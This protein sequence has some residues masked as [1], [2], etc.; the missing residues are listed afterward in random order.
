MR[1]VYIIIGVY[2]ALCTISHKSK[3]R[4]IIA[5]QY[6]ECGNSR[7]HVT[8]TRSQHL[9]LHAIANHLLAQWRL[10]SELW[11]I[12]ES[13]VW[14]ICVINNDDLGIGLGTVSAQKYFLTKVRINFTMIRTHDHNI[15]YHLH[16]CPQRD[17]R[18]I[19]IG[20]DSFK[21][22]MCCVI[23][24]KLICGCLCCTS[25]RDMFTYGHNNTVMGNES[26]NPPCCESRPLLFYIIYTILPYI[27]KHMTV[28]YVLL[29]LSYT[30]VS[31][32]WTWL[33]SKSYNVL[34]SLNSL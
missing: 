17:C 4:E 34:L 19:G 26:F 7:R 3:F 5:R 22:F 8:K 16:T 24:D 31:I 9:A 11:K 13:H 27:L 6:A 23:A 12:A 33:F 14:C 18:Y 15:F 28:T 2:C 30:Y 1:T 25:R 29:Y 20:P 21:L 32:W 10:N